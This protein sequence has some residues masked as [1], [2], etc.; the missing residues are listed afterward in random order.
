MA[1]PRSGQVRHFDGWNGWGKPEKEQDISCFHKGFPQ[2]FQNRQGRARITFCIH[3]KP[4][5]SLSGSVIILKK[6]FSFSMFFTKGQNSFF[7]GDVRIALGWSMASPS[8]SQ[9]NSWRVRS[10]AS[11]ALRGHWNRPFPSRRFW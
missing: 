5:I 10:L 2:Y 11:E 9:R 7:C 4:W 6:V 1:N 8:I 3:R